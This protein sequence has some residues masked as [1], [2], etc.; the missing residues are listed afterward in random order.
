MAQ[1]VQDYMD[2][3]E[4]RYGF[5]PANSQE[6]VFAAQ[7]IAEQ[8]QAHGLATVTEEYAQV[9]GWPYGAY[10]NSVEE[11]SCAAEAGIRK[12]DI[13]TKL[14]DTEIASSAELISVKNRYS[15]GDT[16]ELTVYR[17][18]EEL[19]LSITFDESENPTESEPPAEAQHPQN[20][21]QGNQFTN[22]FGSLFPFGF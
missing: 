11:N 14:G 8:L 18:G 1:Q 4:E 13:I 21:Y 22:P 15:P 2:V 6:E 9:F 3:L 5:A 17:S 10:V 16:V 20:N 7:T 19:T 12:G